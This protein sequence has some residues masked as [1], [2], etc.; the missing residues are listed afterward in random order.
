MWPFVKSV[1]LGALVGAAPLV[2]FTAVFALAS[3]P[4]MLT[5]DVRLLFLVW[6]ATLPFV[7]AFTLVLGVSLPVGLLGTSLRLP[8]ADRS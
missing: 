7:V 1:L 4:D 6:L 8:A 2:V 5:G 3:L